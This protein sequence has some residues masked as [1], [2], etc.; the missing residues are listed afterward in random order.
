[1]AQPAYRLARLC[2][3]RTL[4]LVALVTSSVTAVLAFS[5][6]IS[7]CC[8]GVTAVGHGGVP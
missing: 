1:M 4:H 8:V 2:A 5:C 6:L 7:L 3:H